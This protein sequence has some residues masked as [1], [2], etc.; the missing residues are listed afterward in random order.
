I[1]HGSGQEKILFTYLNDSGKKN[2]QK[3]VFEGIIPNLTRRYRETESQTV[4]EE[5]GK[6]LNATV[7]PDCQGTRL[8]TAARHV[9]V[10][11]RTIYEISAFPLKQ[12]KAFFDQLALPGHRQSIAERIVKE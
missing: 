4:R 12:A 5:L 3:H 1:L 6:Y 2:Q 11:D 8:C 7:C 9:F 10:G